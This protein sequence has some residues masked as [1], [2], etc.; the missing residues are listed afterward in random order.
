MVYQYVAYKETG[1]VVKGKLS[2]T[3]EEAAIDMLGY[4]GY[5]VMN[6]KP[7]AP[8]L[9]LDKLLIRLFRVNP[10]EI[11]LFY[12]QLALLLES[13]IDIVTALEL[14]QVKTSSHALKKAMGEVISDLRG[15][16]QLSSALGKHPEI[17][18]PMYCRL[19]HIGEQTGGLEI[20][21]RQIADY[22]EKEATTAKG[23][24][25]ALMYPVIAAI[26]TVVVVGI[27]ITFVLPS[28]GRLYTSLGAELPTI[29]KTLIDTGNIFQSYGIYILLGAL[30]AAGLVFA[31]I[32]TPGGKYKW[33]KLALSLPQLGYVNH[34]NELARCCRSIS[35]LFR[36]GLPLTEIMPLTIQGSSNEVITRALLDVQQNMLKGEG[37]SQPMAKNEL[38][39]P[40]MVQMVKVGEETGK[41]DTT[42]LAVS[43]SYETE[44]EDK[45]HSFIALI[46]PTMTI[47]IG[48]II[49]FIAL[50]LASAMYSIYGQGV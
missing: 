34:I 19:L 5:K 31:Y 7:L 13:G 32:K 50:S 41:L 11:I 30:A 23:I 47:I 8:F 33:D 17:F 10:A 22:M 44:A 26:T 3:N 1:E 9:S 27:L 4:A 46:Q 24:K 15:G 6:L 12:R 42:L 48:L 39:L 25:N 29:T 20:M 49:G 16:S 45:T 18:S 2:A 14:L 40:M 38:F 35:L 28:I 43:Q 21:L 36:A 37:L